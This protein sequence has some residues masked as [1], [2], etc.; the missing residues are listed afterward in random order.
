MHHCKISHKKLWKLTNKLGFQSF[1][2]FVYTNDGVWV[3]ASIPNDWNR[4][5]I[6]QIKEHETI[7]INFCFSFTLVAI[8][9]ELSDDF[10]ISWVLQ[11]L[12]FWR[13][14]NV[15][16]IWRKV[17]AI[18]GDRPYTLSNYIVEQSRLGSHILL[19]WRT[20]TLSFCRKPNPISFRWL[21]FPNPNSLL[22][23]YRSI[24]CLNILVGSV[25]YLITLLK[26]SLFHYIV[27]VYPKILHCWALPNPNT[28]L[29]C[30]LSYYIAKQFSNTD[31]LL[32]YTQS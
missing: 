30:N 27:E 32:S 7:S 5:F 20:H 9:L 18:W 11:L 21:G 10:V 6:L 3:Q 2:G 23:H 15:E 28:L 19:H 4:S 16:T 1:F 12:L 25:G 31:T 22:L 26:Y 29:R 24:P 13:P 14:K 17:G 8:C